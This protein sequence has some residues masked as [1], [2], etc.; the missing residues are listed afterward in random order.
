[1]LEKIKKI[2]GRENMFTVLYC[3]Y[4]N[5]LHRSDP[6]AVDLGKLRGW[7][8]R[9]RDPF[10]GPPLPPTPDPRTEALVASPPAPALCGSD[11]ASPSPPPPPPGLALWVE[12]CLGR[13]VLLSLPAPCLS[14]HLQP[15]PQPYRSVHLLRLEVPRLQRPLPSHTAPTSSKAENGPTR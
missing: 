11:R 9:G 5:Y 10:L 3:C 4:Q 15:P 1:M 13:Q 6:C 14:A 7:R 2:I 12:C 8:P